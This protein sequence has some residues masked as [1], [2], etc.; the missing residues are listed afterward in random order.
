MIM[1]FIALILFLNELDE[2]TVRNTFSINPL[3]FIFIGDHGIAFPLPAPSINYER[4]VGRR[5]SVYGESGLLFFIIPSNIEFG[6]SFYLS[7]DKF[8]GWSISS[9]IEFG[10]RNFLV[11]IPLNLNYKWI[12]SSR[13]TIKPFIGGSLW[14]YSEDKTLKFY[15]IPDSFG[16]YIGKSW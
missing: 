14:I 6:S 7:P 5:I 9:G 15:P 16:I 13:F 2:T 8:D 1:M 3:S 10:W 4:K 12:H 11:R